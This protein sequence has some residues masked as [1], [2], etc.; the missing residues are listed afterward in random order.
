M[1]NA[2]WS[3]IHHNDQYS[4]R[5]HRRVHDR[6]AGLGGGGFVLQKHLRLQSL[7]VAQ[8]TDAAVLYDCDEVSKLQEVH[9]MR[10][11]DSGFGGQQT[12]NTMCPQLLAHMGVHCREGVI[13]KHH[14]RVCTHI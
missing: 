6:E 1:T 7:E 4:D 13:Q 9:V 2:F 11:Q 12:A 10:D 8:M 3:P 14:I 5:S